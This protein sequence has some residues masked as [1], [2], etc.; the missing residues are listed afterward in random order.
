MNVADVVPT[1]NDV[2]DSEKVN[3]ELE[4]TEQLSDN[5][6]SDEVESRKFNLEKLEDEL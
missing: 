3:C 2:S 5:E 6:Q 1:A 4:C